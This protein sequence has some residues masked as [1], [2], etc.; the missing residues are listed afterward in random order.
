MIA[1]WT[2]YNCMIKGFKEF[3]LR[4]IFIL[5]PFVL[6]VF[7]FNISVERERMFFIQYISALF[8]VLQQVCIYLILV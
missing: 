8:E 5:I 7:G 6:M 1:R 2:H 4:I 3:S